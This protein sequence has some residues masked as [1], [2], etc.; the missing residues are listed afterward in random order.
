MMRI[1]FF[2]M[3]SLVTIAAAGCVGTT[4]TLNTPVPAPASPPA[5]A[6]T[7][8]PPTTANTPTA[9]AQPTVNAAPTTG[10]GL[11]IDDPTLAKLVQDAKTDLTARANV[12]VDAITVTSAQPVEWRDAALGCPIEGQMYAQVITPGYFILLVANDEEY[13]YHA[14]QNSVRFCRKN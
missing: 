6:A 10:S 14:S 3:L 11:V 5:Q 9:Q 12:S 8:L 13:E 7:P 2:L 4:Q 1:V